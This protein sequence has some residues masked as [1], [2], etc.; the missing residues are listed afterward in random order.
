MNWLRII[1]LSNWRN[2]LIAL[3]L[4]VGV[5][6]L[7]NSRI[8]VESKVRI[9]VRMDLSGSPGMAAEVTPQF[10]EAV[11]RG[12][13]RSIEERLSRQLPPITPHL[14]IRLDEDSEIPVA[15]SQESIK[16]LPPDVRPISIQPSEV[17]VKL[18]RVKSKTLRVKADITGEP[19]AGYSV[20]DVWADPTFVEVRG[21]KK[22]LDSASAV[23]TEP[24]DVSGKDASFTMTVSI[25]PRLEDT[26]ISCNIPIKVSV[27]IDRAK[28]IRQKELP[29][30]LIVPADYEY[31]IVLQEKKI[32]VSL[33]GPEKI[34][35]ELKPED[36]YLVLRALYKPDLVVMNRDRCELFGPSSEDVRL[37]EDV[38]AEYTAS[39]KTKGN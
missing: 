29:V 23:P 3:V 17:L 22:V 30:Q 2:K 12:P 14:K 5:W 24:I 1:F 21:A 15:L 34:L 10:V 37:V 27:T 8:T 9:E 11:L 19:A 25:A 13:K 36:C 31:D 7:V 26:A 38:Y 39:K 6:L 35:D 28:V 33:E 18:T 16:G 4:A 32:T 20:T